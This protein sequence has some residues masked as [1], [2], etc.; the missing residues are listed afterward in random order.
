[1]LPR[2]NRSLIGSMNDAMKALRFSYEI[3]KTA[4]T[5]FDLSRVV[6]NLN[7]NPYKALDYDDPSRLLPKLLAGAG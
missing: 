6:T 3:A 5:P 7:R 1:V 4:G 2:T